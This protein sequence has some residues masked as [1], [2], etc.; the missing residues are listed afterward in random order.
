[1]KG[2]LFSADFVKDSNGNVRLLEL[3]TD[4]AFTSGSLSHVDFTDFLNIL[5]TNEINEVHVIGKQMHENFINHLSQSLHG[6]VTN[7]LTTIEEPATIYPT[8]IEDTSTKFILRCAYD[9]SALFDSTYCKQKEEVLKLFYDNDATA[10]IAQFFISS[11]TSNIDILERTTNSQNSPDVVVKNSSNVHEPIKFYKIGGNG[12]T[13][14]NFNEFIE[15][16]YEDSLIVNYYDNSSEPRHKSIRSYNIIYGSNLDILNLSGVEID[17][18]FDKPLVIDEYDPLTNSNL[19]N[20]KH[21]YEFSTNYPLTGLAGGIFE[22]EYIT[23]INDNAVLVVSASL[24]EVYKSIYISGS[25]DTD[26]VSVFTTWTSPGSELPA[27]SFVTSSVLI[28]SIKVPLRRK[29]ISHIT[30]L[31]SGSFRATGNQHILTYDSASDELKYKSIARVDNE[32][33]FLLKDDGTIIGIL[34]ND[35]EI[36]E[37]E[38]YTYILDFENV[39]TFVLNEN[40]LNIKVVVHNACFPAGTKIKLEN[41][42][43]KNIEEV[44]EGDSVISFDTLNKKFTVGRVSKINKSIQT[45]LIH[46][47]TESGEEL[48]STLGHKIYS[49]NGWVLAKDLKI[50]DELI[51]SSGDVSVIQTIDIIKGEFEVYHLLNVG[52]DHTYFANEILVHNWSF[53]FIAGT[54]ITLANGEVKPIENVLIGDEVLTYNEKNGIHE[55]GIVGD[56]KEHEVSQVIKLTFNNGNNIITT[57]EHPFFVIDKGWINA[58]ELQI[59][60]VCKKVDESKTL[61]SNIELLEE[62]HMVYNLLSVSNNHNFYANGV[63]VHNK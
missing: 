22:D 35:I 40:G 19:I 54:L 57:P 44:E 25:P 11:S 29:I 47:K 37:D 6:V 56:L 38:H 59:N 41:G 18:I 2:T 53:C 20:E 45:D 36:L 16:N 9:E 8:A 34:S 21:F 12:N 24:G 49:Q 33:D 48:K 23:D 15:N 13:T 10:S 42:D 17:A 26:N 28:N 3:N 43:T 60:D 7:F 5:S 51:N 1:M 62:T 58:S 55:T 4:T 63:L 39:D 46:L 14:E 61:I 27:G 31:D 50:G 30:T 52:S 32:T